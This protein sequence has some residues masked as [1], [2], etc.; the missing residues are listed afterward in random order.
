[1]LTRPDLSEEPD[2]RLVPVAEA[3]ASGDVVEWGTLDTP[4]LSADDRALLRGLHD[5]AD[6]LSAHERLGREVEAAPP[7]AAGEAGL[8]AWGPLIVREYLGRGSFGDVYRAW[9]PR[10]DREVALKLLAEH[11]SLVV[12]R[13]SDVIAEGR[14]L[15]RVRHPNVV[16]VY[17]ADRIA[18][19]VGVWME[20]VEGQTLAQRVALEGPLDALEV[21]RIGIDLAHA[22]SAVHGAGLL[23]RDVKGQN[24]MC[25]RGGRV[26]LT[27]FGTAL[28]SDGQGGDDTSGTRDAAGPAEAGGAGNGQPA[29]LAGTPLYLAPESL[30]GATPSPR[31]DIYALGVLL[32]HLVTGAFP[33]TGRSLRELRDRHR[34]GQRSTLN[35]VRGDLPPAFVSAVD[36]A[37]SVSPSDRFQS[38]GEMAEALDAFVRPDRRTAADRAAHVPVA[39]LVPHPAVPSRSAAT[40]RRVAWT[41]AAVALIVAAVGA[42]FW[43]WRAASPAAGSD[44]PPAARDLVLVAAVDGGPA[45]AGLAHIVE[46]AITLAVTR[47]PGFTPV[48]ADRLREMLPFMKRPPDTRLDAQTARELALRDGGIRALVT[49]AITRAGATRRLEANLVVPESGQVLDTVA[50]PVAANDDAVRAS[51]ALASKIAAALD[52]H[53]AALPSPT[54]RFERVTTAS[55]EALRAYTEGREKYN[56][57]TRPAAI[58]AEPHFERAIALDPFFAMAHTWLGWAVQNSP[59]AV[60]HFAEG[61]RLATD[62]STEERLWARNGHLW[63]I[64]DDDARHPILRQLLGLD[65]L[66]RLALHNIEFIDLN[67]I[68]SF[69]EVVGNWLQ[70]AEARPTDPETI[71]R[72][73]RALLSYAPWA[74]RGLDYVR[75][76]NGLAR[77]ADTDRTATLTSF[78]ALAPAWDLWARG[79]ALGASQRLA[80]LCD[81][82][83][84]MPKALFRLHLDCGYLKVGLGDLRGAQPHA[85]YTKD[86]EIEAFAAEFRGDV[87]ELRALY[88]SRIRTWPPA[89]DRAWIA[90][91]AGTL[92]RGGARADQPL[93][94]AR[95]FKV[96]HLADLAAP[97]PS[98]DVLEL[99]ERRWRMFPRPTHSLLRLA[100]AYAG[101][102]ERTGQGDR[103]RGVLRTA[104][105]NRRVTVADI[106]NVPYW[107]A[108]RNAYAELLRRQHR[109]GEAEAVERELLELLSEADADHVIA[110]RLRKRYVG[111]ATAGA[112][113]TR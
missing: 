40:R 61:E 86:Q 50:E 59:D 113:G 94:L 28:T 101:A 55:F 92:D 21:A 25:G 76:L 105:E 77:G 6:I 39:G 38:A 69:E 72:T 87:A 48:P 83:E 65:P 75:R 3:V 67:R 8:H 29:G 81:T 102:L 43:R 9:D 11:S 14:A 56:E 1:V 70:Q 17:G 20:F 44:A 23:H 103:A 41:M 58:A 51:E 88:Q 66:N 26:V 54:A 106:G 100:M 68:G 79:D 12:E 73:S 85:H 22:L 104:T 71:Y 16:T 90:L 30:D 18:G 82:R 95:E 96:R 84:T 19:R 45:D 31:S 109:D 99:F 93:F 52:V 13:D 10:L 78:A 111:T 2:A 37:L 98:R 74:D 32:Y 80:T 60:A 63:A 47:T 57:A 64:K 62:A 42:G 15:A 53:R 4:D 108:A 91:Q 35:E 7:H 24:V 46:N 34:T 107:I 5:I 27:D 110:A 97:N 33:V 36:R 89:I 49:G 112:A